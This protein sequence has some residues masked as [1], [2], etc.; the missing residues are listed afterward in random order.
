MRCVASWGRGHVRAMPRAD[1]SDRVWLVLGGRG[2][3]RGRTVGKRTMG[4]NRVM[5][6]RGALAP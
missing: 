6:T 5:M 1:E 3:L 4:K 2:V